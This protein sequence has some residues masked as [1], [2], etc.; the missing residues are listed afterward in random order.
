MRQ[1]EHNVT[2]EQINA[3]AS[4]HYS[5]TAEIICIQR[6]GV[7]TFIHHTVL[8]RMHVDV[9]KLETRASVSRGNRGQEIELTR[10]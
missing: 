3:L 8:I 2:Y 6:N 1:Q 10:N 9:A 7:L 4:L 5:E